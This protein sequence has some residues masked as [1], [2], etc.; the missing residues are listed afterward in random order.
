MNHDI[1]A[2]SREGGIS[3]EGSSLLDRAS[4]LM[5]QDDALSKTWLQLVASAA[6]SGTVEDLAN[7]A[8]APAESG[9]RSRFNKIKPHAKDIVVK[10]GDIASAAYGTKPQTYDIATS[11]AEKWCTL[12]SY[13]GEFIP[14]PV[15]KDGRRDPGMGAPRRQ[16][17][18]IIGVA[19]RDTID[20]TVSIAVSSQ[21]AHP[22]YEKKLTKTTKYL[23]HDEYGQCKKGDVI[24]AVESRPLS[25]RKHHS[26]VA[27]IQTKK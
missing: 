13:A 15:I 17:R 25:K 4:E 8:L 9:L 21:I 6:D 16:P 3:T 2:L 18:K 19:L 24:V 26:F 10:A 1:D 5:A 11:I 7:D 23:V 27:K 12:A 14:F 22:V 20:K